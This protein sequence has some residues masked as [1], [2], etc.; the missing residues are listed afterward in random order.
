MTSLH[1][2]HPKCKEDGAAFY[3]LILA[4]PGLLIGQENGV[5]ETSGVGLHFPQPLEQECHLLQLC[6]YERARRGKSADTDS[7]W[8]VA[9]AGGGEDGRCLFVG[10]GFSRG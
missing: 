7:G 3:I 5:R 4:Q 8:V 10:A 9:W 6:L 1:E 2:I